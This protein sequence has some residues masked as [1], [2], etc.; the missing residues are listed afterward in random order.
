LK[1]QLKVGHDRMTNAGSVRKIQEKLKHGPYGHTNFCPVNW[2]AKIFCEEDFINVV[3]LSNQRQAVSVNLML[4]GMEKISFCLSTMLQCTTLAINN[5]WTIL[6]GHFPVN[7]RLW[8]DTVYY[9]VWKLEVLVVVECGLFMK[10]EHFLK[11]SI[12][13]VVCVGSKVCCCTYNPLVRNMNKCYFVSNSMQPYVT[14]PTFITRAQSQGGKIDTANW[15][16]LYYANEE[17]LEEDTQ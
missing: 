3:K 1:R 4:E 6:R 8:I 12:R 15:G 13:A 17:I 11:S 16:H 5:M 2:R 10:I 14:W 9:C 7:L